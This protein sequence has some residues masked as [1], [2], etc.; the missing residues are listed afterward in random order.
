VILVDTSVWIDHFRAGD[1]LLA[2][3]LQDGQVLGHPWVTGEIAL[4]SLA[5]R[6]E[7]VGLLL[8]LSQ[9]VVASDPRCWR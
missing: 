4:G 1:D 7:V 6:R 3:L 2:G 9:A 8:D 5:Q